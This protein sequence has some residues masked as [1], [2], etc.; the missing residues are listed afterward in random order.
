M[1][2]APLDSLIDLGKFIFKEK[3]QKNN[4]NIRLHTNIQN[5]KSY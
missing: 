3:I 5:R 4:E 2:T 1:D